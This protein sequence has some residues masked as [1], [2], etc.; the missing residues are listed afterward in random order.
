VEDIN[1]AENV[2]TI[3]LTDDYT[4]ALTSHNDTKMVHKTDNLDISSSSPSIELRENLP[5]KMV[6]EEIVVI[7][8]ESSEHAAIVHDP[9][10]PTWHLF[11]IIGGY[12][13]H[14]PWL[15]Q[16]IG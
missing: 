7:L 16:R 9:G 10:L 12:M 1:E 8:D 14:I 6:E 5:E 11:V 13:S 4:L 3:P 2:S 15:T